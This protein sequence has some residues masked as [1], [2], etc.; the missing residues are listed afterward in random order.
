MLT[1][2][3]NSTITLWNIHPGK[4]MGT[5][6]TSW[7]TGSSQQCMR[8]IDRYKVLYSGSSMGTVHSWNV[9]QACELSSIQLHDDIVTKMVDIP[10]QDAIATAS[11]DKT[12]KVFDLSTGV[13][14]L[15]RFNFSHISCQM[16]VSPSIQGCT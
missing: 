14:L 4:Q 13:E 16:P 6:I 5:K 10:S 1:A 9:R 11:H 2:S 7:P 12:S 3:A 15:V 8:F